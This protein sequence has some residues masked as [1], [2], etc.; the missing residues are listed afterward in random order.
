MKR[1]RETVGSRPRRSGGRLGDLFQLFP[2]L[3][4]PRAVP[5]SEQRARLRRRLEQVQQRM[6]ESVLRQ[7]A[8]AA[9][10]RAKWEAVRK[11]S[12]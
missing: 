9:R 3:P 10:F 6:L 4:G 8:A 11:R 2:D 7:R 1:G 5:V 12:K